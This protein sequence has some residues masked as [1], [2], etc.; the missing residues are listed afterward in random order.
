MSMPKI[1]DNI[2]WLLI[3]SLEFSGLA[4]DAIETRW[5]FI[6]NF[7]RDHTPTSCWKDPVD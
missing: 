5:Q 7:L 3:N 6:D 2:V 1:G 4:D